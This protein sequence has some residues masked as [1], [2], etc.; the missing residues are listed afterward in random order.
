VKGFQD[1]FVE[2][3]RDLK[4]TPAA[5]LIERQEVLGDFLIELKKQGRTYKQVSDF[6]NDAVRRQM[7]MTY[8]GEHGLSWRTDPNVE[9][10]FCDVYDRPLGDGEIYFRESSSSDAPLPDLVCRGGDRFQLRTRFYVGPT[11]RIE[12]DVMIEQMGR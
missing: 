4:P 6:R 3:A 1:R 8:F 9:I 7:A 10:Y 5:S 12:H 11:N 2:Y